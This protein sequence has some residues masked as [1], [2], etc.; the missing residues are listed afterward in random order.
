M[1]IVIETPE[2][3]LVDFENILDILRRKTS[4][5]TVY[6]HHLESKACV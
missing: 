5:F 2:L 1:C 3:T 6:R 4:H